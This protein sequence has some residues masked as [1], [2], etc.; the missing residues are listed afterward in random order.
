MNI[1]FAPPH[2]A[3]S[4]LYLSLITLQVPRFGHLRRSLGGHD[5]GQS[6]VGGAR[7]LARS[8]LIRQRWVPRH[9]TRPL[10]YSLC[11]KNAPWE[12]TFPKKGAQGCISSD[13][14]EGAR[15]GVLR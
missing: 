5:R 7:P 1:H 13:G 11:R 14:Q 9:R 3:L 6:E 2:L 8:A 12:R 15:R 10:K 4:V